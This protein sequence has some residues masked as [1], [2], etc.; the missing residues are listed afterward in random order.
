VETT[1]LLGDGFPARYGDRT[2]GVIEVR[3]KDPGV[4]HEGSAGF[5]LLNAHAFARG[6]PGERGGY[7]GAARRG[8]T[9]LFLDA[10][11]PDAGFRPSYYDLFGKVEQRAGERDEVAL[12]GKILSPATIANHNQVGRTAGGTSSDPTGMNGSIIR[13]DPDTGAGLPTNPLASSTDPAAR[14]IIASG[15]RNPF[16][17]T[18]RPGTSEIWVGDVGWNDWE[19]I[20]RIASPTAGLMNFGWYSALFDPEPSFYYPLPKGAGVDRVMRKDGRVQTVNLSDRPVSFDLTFEARAADSRS[21]EVRWNGKPLATVPIGPDSLEA[22]VSGFTLD[23]GKTGEITFAASGGT[24]E[25]SFDVGQGVIPLPAT[26]V[27]ANV[28]IN[29]SPKSKA[30]SPK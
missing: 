3:T 25:Y 21:L 2:G 8:Y 30:Q 7:L 10:W 12:Y 19:E 13:I 15:L 6:P 29:E 24:F 14:R 26:A 23:A 16:R 11:A 4:R 22:T 18:T 5:D 17:I 28:R 20:D 1:T 9:D 27:L